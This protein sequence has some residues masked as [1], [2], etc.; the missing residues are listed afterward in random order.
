MFLKHTN[1]D[2]LLYMRQNVENVLK[3]LCV[4]LSTAF[5]FSCSNAQS[6]EIAH[7]TDETLKNSA[8]QKESELLWTRELESVRL[9]RDYSKNIAASKNF[10]LSPAAMAVANTTVSSVYPSL[11]GFGS[12]DSSALSVEMLAFLDSEC[13]H[14]ALWQLDKV[15]MEQDSEFSLVLFK[16]DVETLWK[17]SFFKPFPVN[18][19]ES[20]ESSAENAETFRLFSGW[21]YGRPFFDGDTAAVP[22]RF[23]GADGML[24]IC[25][26]V[27]T[28][29]SFCIRQIEIQNLQQK[30]G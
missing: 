5:F 30:K 28:D 8:A 18:L 14:I 22:V 29:A 26:Y 15:R 6:I 2:I 21:I 24:D 3:I 17:K 13:E 20:S 12:L 27:R 11:P 16:F 9:T 4:F 10:T 19:T 1:Y 25:L 23:E 7:L